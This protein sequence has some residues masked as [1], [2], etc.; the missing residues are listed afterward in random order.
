MENLSKKVCSAIKKQAADSNDSPKHWEESG[1][2]GGSISLLGGFLF[3]SCG[4]WSCGG[5]IWCFL[6]TFLLRLR[7]FVFGFLLG[8]Y[9]PCTIVLAHNSQK[10]DFSGLSNKCCLLLVL[11][12]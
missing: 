10:P 6:V 11:L 4:C 8:C 1:N 9:F 7:I 5:I 12:K 2:C 3:V